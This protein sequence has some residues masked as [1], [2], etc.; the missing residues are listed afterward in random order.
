MPNQISIQLEA[1]SYEFAVKFLRA[2]ICLFLV[3]W[4]LRSGKLRGLLMMEG[5]EM[6]MA[7]S[8]RTGDYRV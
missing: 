5:V 2:V 7:E 8:Q 1:A 6:S 4:S 3:L